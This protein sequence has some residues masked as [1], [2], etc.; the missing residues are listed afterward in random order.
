MVTMSVGSSFD[1]L[2][3]MSP[4]ASLWNLG[5]IS[6]FDVCRSSA[7]NRSRNDEGW[8]APEVGPSTRATLPLMA[9]FGGYQSWRGEVLL[10]Q[11][12]W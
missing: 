7:P 3:A 10:A 1:A 8:G 5:R 12:F 2:D 11:Q 9:T 4:F 6:C